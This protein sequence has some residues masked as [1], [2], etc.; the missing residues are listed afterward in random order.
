MLRQSRNFVRSQRFLEIAEDSDLDRLRQDD[1]RILL[2]D[3]SAFC[4]AK[5]T[6][7]Y[8]IKMIDME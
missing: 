2:V 1:S 4:V 6:N 8:I 3:F 5:R 7:N